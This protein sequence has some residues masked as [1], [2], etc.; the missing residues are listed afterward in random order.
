MVTE[1][2][3]IPS[4]SFKFDILILIGC[5]NLVWTIQF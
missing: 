3:L 1:K 2:N 4:I 5:V